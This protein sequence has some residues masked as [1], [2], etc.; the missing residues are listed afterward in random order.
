MKFASVPA[1][2]AYL[3]IAILASSTAVFASP[4]L[5]API[6]PIKLASSPLLPAP[7]NPIKLA[8]SPLLPAPINPIKLA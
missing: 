7:I 1:F 6:N 4:L 2:R 5:P 8:S 3:T